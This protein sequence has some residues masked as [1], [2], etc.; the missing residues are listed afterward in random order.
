M[1]ESGL[2]QV[3]DL[4][5]ANPYPNPAPLERAA[6]RRLLDNAWHGRPPAQA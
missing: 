1:P 5:V 6:I 4:A 3:A 2:D